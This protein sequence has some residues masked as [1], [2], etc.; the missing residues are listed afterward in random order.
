MLKENLFLIQHSKL[1]NK[2]TLLL[3]IF[4]WYYSCNSTHFF[5]FKENTKLSEIKKIT[6]QMKVVLKTLNIKTQLQKNIIFVNLKPLLE[7]KQEINK[8]E[9]C[10]L[11]KTARNM[12]FSDGNYKSNVMLIGEAPGEE[13]DKTGIP[14]K[15]QAGL[16]L[17]KMLNAI[18]Q[19]RDNTYITN[20][21]F[22]RPP[23]NRNPTEEEIDICL[24]F[25]IRHIELVKPKILILTGAIAAKAILKENIGII[26]LRGKWNNLKISKSLTIKTMP[27]LHPAFL[28]RQ[29]SRKRE[30]WED[31]K[32][33]K[34][35]IDL[36]T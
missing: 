5:S 30:A 13:E 11:K 26:Q 33:I 12:V 7:L 18:G 22:W 20:L 31:L 19:N 3:N 15:G 32:K 35:E 28:L 2:S 23:G 1:K 34:R 8:F 16:L 21:I 14:F 4:K 6:D 29:P 9:G 17:D 27:I 25:V 36:I 24:P 10:A